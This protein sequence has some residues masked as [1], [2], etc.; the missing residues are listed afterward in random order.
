ME[1][2]VNVLVVDDNH[3][4]VENYEEALGD[5]GYC[6]H[7]AFDLE[8][9]LNLLDRKFFHVAIVDVR[10]DET[11]KD[12]LQG[13]DV[14]QRIWEL[15]E[16]TA[17]IMVSGFPMTDLLP[18]FMAYQ[19][20]D[21]VKREREPDA[22]AR[23]YRSAAFI[24]GVIDKLGSPAE[25]LER[26][27]RAAFAARRAYSR[28]KWLASPVGFFGG[29]SGKG[30]QGS[31]QGAGMVE[32]WPFLGTLCR[33]FFPWIHSAQAAIHV[34]DQESGDVGK[35]LAIEGCA[36]SRMLGKPLIIRFGRRGLL[37]Q[38]MDIVPL[39]VSCRGAR[40]G[41]ELV[42]QRSAHF[43]GRAWAVDGVSFGE[44]FSPP[45]IRRTSRA[46]GGLA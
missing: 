13:L 24:K 36:W 19:V 16:G 42:H 26:V 22:I 31:L 15:D 6:A 38:S 40:I 14:L 10:L 35:V 21:F 41:A 27:E 20:F 17:A 2:R 5:L 33:P 3:S 39:G 28:R 29:L 32:L 8:T 11:D 37:V 25:A 23:Q 44:A 46:R 30:M 34:T 43:E 18:S 12:N 7:A 45:P 1:D 4:W 9:A